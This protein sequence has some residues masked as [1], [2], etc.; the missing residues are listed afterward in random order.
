MASSTESSYHIVGKPVPR[1]E[2]AGKVSG[3]AEYTADVDL[4]GMVWAK[5]VRSPHPH[6]RIISIDFSKAL[7]LPGVLATLTAKDFPNIPTGRNIKDVP[8]LCDD[9]VRFIGDKVAVVAAEDRQTAEKAA[10]LVEVQYEELPAV[11]DPIEAMEPGAPILHADPRSYVG[12]PEAVPDDLRNVCG[13]AVWERGDVEKGFAEADHIVENTFRTQLAHQGYLEPTASVVK[14]TPASGG[15]GERVEVWAS[16]KVPYALRKEFARVLDRPEEDVL[17]HAVTIG[18]DFGAKS[19]VGDLPAAYYLA[20]KLSSP[21]KFVNSAQEDLT[22]AAPKHAIITQLRTGV[23]NDGKIVANQA[24]VW[25]NRGAYTG[26]NTSANGLLGGPA[27]AGNFY[28]IPNQHIEAF[29]VYTNRVPCGFMRAPGSPQVLFAVESHM[30]V[31]ARQIGM[32]PVEF[33]KR[34]V[35]DTAPSGAATVAHR[36]LDAA[37]DAFGWSSAAPIK[38]PG[39][40]V[41]RGLALI[42]RNQGAGIGSSAITVNTDGTVSALTS[43]PDNGTGGLTVVAAVVAETFGIPLERVRLIRGDTDAL[44]IDV[45]SGG[46]RMTNTA[47]QVALAASAQV[48]EQLAPLAARAMGVSQAQ[49]AG[50][51]PGGWS[52][53][54]GKFITL[55]NL[56][57]ELVKE[58]DPAAHAQVTL[59]APRSPDPGICVQM[60]EVEVDAETGKVTL[61]RIVSAQDVGTIIN[62][63]GHQGQIDGSVMQGVGHALMEELVVEDGRITTPNFNDYRMPTIQ[64]IPQ[65]TTVNVPEPGQGPFNAKSIGE[66]PHIPTGGAIA[67][68]VADAIGVTVLELPITAERVFRM[69][70]SK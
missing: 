65:L 1:V 52:G 33:R 57:T 8:L 50:G 43:M 45:E 11:F 68:A 69:L 40:L 7:Q 48:Q 67:N 54:E 21:V 38:R 53:G 56:A 44:P 13:Y 2:G 70:S 4:P 32:D 20:K 64:D 35:P 47:G 6:A 9:V 34:N 59:T 30:D 31:I 66:I 25:I 39:V 51:F 46:S 26:H 29:G 62:T 58:G 16:N 28:T 42:D 18:G 61:T 5:N 27:K 37:S 23:T 10:G 15:N 17:V 19:S 55:E 41:G 60:A 12:F 49:W 24:K 63:L 36:V 22:A 3:R 14:I